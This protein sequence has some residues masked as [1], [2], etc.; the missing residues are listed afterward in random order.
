MD[1]LGKPNVE[2]IYRR[3][4][5]TRSVGAYLN[6]QLIENRHEEQQ[7]FATLERKLIGYMLY[8][9]DEKGWEA[10]RMVDNIVMA[11]IGSIEAYVASSTRPDREYSVTFVAKL[12]QVVNRRVETFEQ[13][14]YK[15]LPETV[16]FG[17][18]FMEQ[19]LQALEPLDKLDSDKVDRTVVELNLK[20][21]KKLILH[22][23]PLRT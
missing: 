6:N 14:S 12:P 4:G 17:K 18:L 3:I 19:F 2:H 23:L 9:F 20:R 8:V 5:T 15:I 7:L 22:V 13:I 16:D 10:R 21:E 1:K 11:K